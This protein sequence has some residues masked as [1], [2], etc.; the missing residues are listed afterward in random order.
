MYVM[1]GLLRMSL[2]EFTLKPAENVFE[3]LSKNRNISVPQSLLR[4]GL[5]FSGRFNERQM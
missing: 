2:T 3:H 1:S 5:G 4:L